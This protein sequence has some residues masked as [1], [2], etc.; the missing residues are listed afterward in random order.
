MKK[1]LPY[2]MV[3]WFVLILTLGV[4][5]SLVVWA[6]NTPE[7]TRAL[8]KTISTLTPLEIDT[9]E[10]SG[11]LMDDLKIQGLQIRWPQGELKARFFH[12][13][14]RATDLWNRRI[15]I[16][17][18]SLEGVHLKDDRTYTGKISLHGWPT[19]PFWLSKI[20]G[21]VDSLQIQSM[22]YQ[23]LQENP[24]SLDK[25]FTRLQWDGGVLGVTDFTL[26][27]SLIHI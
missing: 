24:V 20:Q 22:V 17:E 7:G 3:G 12:L 26:Q 5:V 16:Q 15:I 25:L 21:R 19:V 18:I 14:W 1:L 13:Q 2:F 10:I 27:L 8:L 11:R 9:Q 4:F 23:R 6:L